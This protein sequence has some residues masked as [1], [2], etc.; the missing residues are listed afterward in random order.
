MKAAEDE[1]VSRSNDE[2][3]AE[4]DLLGPGAGQHQYNRDHKNADGQVGNQTGTGVAAE[5]A[6]HQQNEG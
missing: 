6:Q 1:E 5:N 3:V 2:Q 4:G